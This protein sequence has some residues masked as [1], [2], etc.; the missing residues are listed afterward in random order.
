MGGPLPRSCAAAVR[1]PPALPG[2]SGFPG[3]GIARR[4]PS[5]IAATTSQTGRTRVL[6][7]AVVVV[8]VAVAPAE[9]EVLHAAAGPDAD[10]V[11]VRVD[12]DRRLVLRRDHQ[13]PDGLLG[14]VRDLV[15]AAGAGREADD[16][17]GDEPLGAARAAE[18]RPALQH[19]Q[20][21]LVPVLEV[22][23]ADALPRRKLVERA[24]DQPGADPA[25]EP[26]EAGAI[27]LWIGRV[28]GRLRLEEVEP[29]HTGSIS[30]LGPA[31]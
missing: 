5:S 27:P 28:L 16:V 23:G 2:L 24:A 19:D 10:L 9:H 13:H 25:S 1:M 12:G 31:R 8:H 30:G 29:R 6:G 4:I 17:A 7:L 26:G 11:A 22:V 3:A 20:P 14:Q 15:R 18:R 21:L